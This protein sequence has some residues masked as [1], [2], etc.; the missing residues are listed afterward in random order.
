MKGD[1]MARSWISRNLISSRTLVPLALAAVVGTALLNLPLRAAE[2]AFIIPAPAVDAPAQSGLQ[3]IVLAGGCFW[4]IQA[5]YQH[6]DGVKQAI[7]GYSGGTRQSANYQLVSGGST[8]HAEAVEITFDPQKISYGKI[9]QIFFSVAHNP[10]E[11]NRQGPDSGTQY[12]SNIFYANAEQKQVAEAY[13][14]QL[15]KLGVYNKPIATRID[16]LEGFYA[17]EDY[18]QDYAIKHPNNSYIVFN[19]APKVENLKKVLPDVFRQVPVT[20]AS[21]K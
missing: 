13:I 16:K 20:V 21:A 6:T 8:G 10:T 18:H 4:G 11:L 1:A 7:S 5:V 3:K 14:A 19:D 15:N 17:A 9:L 2:N 12:R